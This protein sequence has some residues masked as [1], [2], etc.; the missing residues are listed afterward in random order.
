MLSFSIP[1]IVKCLLC[2]NPNQYAVIFSL[3]HKKSYYMTSD[4]VHT[5]YKL[6]L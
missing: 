5:S 3:E 4:V 1:D 6:L 2:L